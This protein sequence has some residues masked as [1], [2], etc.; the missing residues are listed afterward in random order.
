MSIGIYKITNI[1]NNKSYIGQSINI[2][3]RFE[4]HINNGSKYSYIDRSIKKHGADNFTFEI[5]ITCAKEDLDKEETKFIKLY[6]T[7][8][9]GYNLT[10]GA[11]IS[12]SKIPEIAAKISKKQQ[13]K[14]NSFYGKKHS[15][16]SRKKMSDKKQNLNGKNN[17]FYD[18]NHSLNHNIMESKRKNT[19]G[20][21]RVTKHK[22][23]TCNQGF[24]YSYRYYDKNKKRRTLQSVDIKKLEQKVKDKGLEWIK[25]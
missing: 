21:F 24:I 17:P 22:D 16:E 6:G 13:G 19:S 20:Y 15:I 4:Q 7:Y 3:K 12:F 14:N 9:D 25:F 18:H 8:K 11:D 23:K 10:W 5:L 1:I 2:E